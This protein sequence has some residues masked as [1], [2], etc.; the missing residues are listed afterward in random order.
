MYTTQGNRP[1]IA[2]NDADKKVDCALPDVVTIAAG[3]I[4]TID[5]DQKE[6]GTPT[7][8]IVLIQGA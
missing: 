7:D 5:I 1:T 4:I 8:L 2:Y 6:T 3:D